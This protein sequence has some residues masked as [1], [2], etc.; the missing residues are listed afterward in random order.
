[1]SVT[2]IRH[3]VMK[4]ARIMRGR[5]HHETISFDGPVC[6]HPDAWRLR[7][8]GRPGLRSFEL[9]GRNTWRQPTRIGRRSSEYDDFHEGDYQGDPFFDGDVDDRDD[10][11][12][13][14]FFFPIK[15]K[16]QWAVAE[17]EFD[18]GDQGLYLYLEFERNDAFIP[19]E[20]DPRNDTSSEW[21]FTAVPNFNQATEEHKFEVYL[22]D[23]TLDGRFEYRAQEARLISKGSG[24]D[25]RIIGIHLPGKGEY[26]FHREESASGALND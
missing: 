20:P 17:L 26:G 18:D 2:G 25:L 23:D 9:A 16:D 13:E 4:C 3:G 22:N 1:M 24:D 21:A 14:V 12:D 19:L 5:N 6:R 8:T 7:G 15:D 11:G 10:F